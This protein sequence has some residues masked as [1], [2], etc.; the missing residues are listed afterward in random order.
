MSGWRSGRSMR[1]PAPGRGSGGRWGRCPMWRCAPASRRGLRGRCTT[2]WSNGAGGAAH[3]GTQRLECGVRACSS[4]SGPDG[5]VP[6]ESAGARL[7][8]DRDEVSYGWPVARAGG[9]GP[10]LGDRRRRQVQRRADAGRRPGRAGRRAGGPA[11]LLTRRTEH[12]RDHAGQICFPGGRSNRMTERRRRGA[13]RGR[14]GDRA[15]D[16][17]RVALIGN[18]PPY[19]TVTGFRIDPVV[20]WISPPFELRPDPYEV[21]EAFEVP[22]HFVLD[23]ENHRRQSYR[24]DPSRGP[25]TWCRT[26]GASSGAPPLAF[27][28]IWQGCSGPEGDATALQYVL[29]LSPAVPD[30]R[31]LRRVGHLGAELARSGETTWFVLGGSG[32][33]LP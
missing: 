8:A 14:R 12:L 24:R 22:L 6:V 7:G 25:I 3:G 2:S 21:A 5:R 28:S 31:R 4:R 15:A 13:A 9:R 1:C 23:P 17:A 18:S 29:A 19:H 26:R 10:G 11:L 30:L 33:V 27:W 32:L 16:P 20:G